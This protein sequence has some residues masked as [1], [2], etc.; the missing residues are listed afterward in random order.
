MCVCF[1]IP[2]ICDVFF[3]ELLFVFLYEIVYVMIELGDGRIFWVVD[4]YG[5]S[6]GYEVACV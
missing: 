2:V 1:V 5:V 4:S 3:P 6:L